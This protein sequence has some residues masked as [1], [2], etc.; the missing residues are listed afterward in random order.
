LNQEERS[1]L[2]AGEFAFFIYFIMVPGAGLEPAWVTPYAPQ[3]Y[4]SAS[5]T[6]PALFIADFGLMILD[7]KFC[8]P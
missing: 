7:F 6:I 3:T 8:N 5:S 1:K 2:T 4:V